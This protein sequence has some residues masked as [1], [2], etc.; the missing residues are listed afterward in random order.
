MFY[1][2]NIVKKVPSRHEARFVQVISTLRSFCLDRA[3]AEAA[4][5][6]QVQKEPK[7][8]RAKPKAWAHV[9]V[10]EVHEGGVHECG[11]E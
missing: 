5:R 8:S 2:N 9:G 11:Y 7:K 1:D 3:F 4:S 10:Y 6:R